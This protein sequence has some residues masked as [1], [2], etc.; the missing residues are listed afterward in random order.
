MQTAAATGETRLDDDRT[1]VGEAIALVRSSAREAMTEME[2][3]LDQLRA[4]PLDNAG[5]VAA[6]QQAMRRAR[7]QD[8]R[9]GLVRRRHAAADDAIDPGVRP[10]MLRIAQ[11]ALANIAR[12][13]RAQNVTV[14]ARIAA[15]VTSLSRSR[16]TA[17]GSIPHRAARAWAF[18]TC[19]RARGDVGG[20]LSRLG[21]GRGTTVRVD[22]PP[23]RTR[24]DRADRSLE[25]VEQQHPSS[26]GPRRDVGRM[27]EREQ[28]TPRRRGH[29]VVLARGSSSSE[30]APAPARVTPITIALVDD[31]R[32]VTRSLQMYLESFPDLRIVGVAASGEELLAHL[33]EWQPQVVLQDLLLPGGIDGIETTKRALQMMPSLRVVALTASV[34]EARMM[35]VLRAGAIGYVR[36]ARGSG[37]AAG[38]GAIGGARAAVHRSRRER[39][40]GAWREAARRSDAARARRA[41]SDRAGTRESRDCVSARHRRRDGEDARR[42]SASR[43]SASK[44]ARRRSSRRSNAD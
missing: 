28:S 26:S 7:V 29:V 32:V 33:R 36:K 13:A 18:V 20:T 14:I 22:V 30:Q 25:A 37:G 31:H 43:S 19:D 40:L 15:D 17:R 39:A 5:L 6:L 38:G 23:A 1:G 41:P 16:T 3:M 42:A 2:A 24:G 11:E 27:P 8:R 34:D 10:A 4:T 44:I 35:G 9:G 21:A 12:H